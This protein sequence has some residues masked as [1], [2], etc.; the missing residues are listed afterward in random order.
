M[1]AIGPHD[2]NS[3]FQGGESIKVACYLGS[4]ASP[5]RCTTARA[6]RTPPKLDQFFWR[7]TI[8]NKEAHHYLAHL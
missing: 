4:Q 5:M 8:G 6:W 1:W 7:L 3:I 2:I